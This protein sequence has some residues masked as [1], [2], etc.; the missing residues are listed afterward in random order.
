MQ[1]QFSH[2]GQYFE[3]FRSGFQ[4]TTLARTI[5]EADVINFAG[6][7]GDFNSIHTDAIFAQ[8]TPFGQRVAHGLLVLSIVTGLAVRTGFL[9]GTVIAFREIEEWKFSRPV[10]IGDNIHAHITVQDTKPLPRLGGG[11]IILS[12]SVKNQHDQVVMKGC[13]SVLVQ[14]APSGEQNAPDNRP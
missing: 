10:F 3:E 9:E 2:R 13:F 8:N 1:N 5:T 4:I 14:N 6:L 11:A 7:S 12:I